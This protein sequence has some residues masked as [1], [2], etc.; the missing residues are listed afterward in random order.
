MGASISESALTCAVAIVRYS[1]FMRG[2][3]TVQVSDRRE[4]PKA[5]CP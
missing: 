4:T 2:I 1:P 5:G 3:A